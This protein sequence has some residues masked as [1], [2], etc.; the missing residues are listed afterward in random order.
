MLDSIFSPNFTITSETNYHLEGIDR[1]AWLIDRMLIMPKHEAWMRREVSVRRAVG[2]T[3]I[4]GATLDEAAVSKLAGQGHMAKYTEDEQVLAM[5]ALTTN[6]RDTPRAT[7]CLL[8]VTVGEIM[9]LV[10][11]TP[12]TEHSESERIMPRSSLSSA[13]VFNPA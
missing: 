9:V 8:T 10:V 11:N 1:R 12:A 3:R 4:E 7:R 5:P 13:K 6:P 2:T